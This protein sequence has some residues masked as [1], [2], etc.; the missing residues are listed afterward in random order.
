LSI[1]FVSWI[2]D[3]LR[4]EQQRREDL[5]ASRRRWFRSR[6]A[7]HLTSFVV[8]TLVAFLRTFQ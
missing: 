1:A 7:A 4:K 3:E 2:N 6:L 8:G 5:A